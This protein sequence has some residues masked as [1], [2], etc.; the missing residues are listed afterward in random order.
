MNADPLP[1]S[2]PPAPPNT[3][4]VRIAIAAGIVFLLAFAVWSWFALTDS[5]V[6][7]FDLKLAT[8]LKAVGDQRTYWR[9]FFIVCTEAGG[10][11]ACI[12]LSA[13]GVAW[14]WRR[15]E[16][17]FAFIWIAI[18]AGG[19]L[20]N[21]TLKEVFDRDRPPIHLRDRYVSETNDSYPSGHAMGSLI[22]YGLWAYVIQTRV[23]NRRVG[24][25]VMCALGLWIGTICFSRVFLRA[26]WLSD[27]IGG[28]LI[29]IAYLTLALTYWELRK[30]RRP[31]AAE[32]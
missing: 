32:L 14:A 18:V 15:K 26:H 17:R 16:K 10:I 1:N 8:A 21:L 3:W 25:A 22:G 6:S 27:V 9:M 20:V 30:M 24:G 7:R 2:Q 28:T 4:P 31:K 11:A 19:G 5:P 12:M 13:V 29:G 23:R